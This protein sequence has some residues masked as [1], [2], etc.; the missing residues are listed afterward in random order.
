MAGPIYQFPET[1]ATSYKPNERGPNIHL[2]DKTG[3]WR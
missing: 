3:K 1:Q 2:K